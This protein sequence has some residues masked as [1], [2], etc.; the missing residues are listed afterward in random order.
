MTLSN[1]ALALIL[2]LAW[3][4]LL[5]G[6]IAALRSWLTLTGARAPNRFDPAG[7][8]VSAFA[9]RLCRAHANCYET[10]PLFGGLLLLALVLGR[11]DATDATALWALGARLGQSLVHLS[12]TSA[13]AVVV[14]FGFFAAQL[15]LFG[16]WIVRLLGI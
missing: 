1:T 14:R 9:G 10:F 12:S 4:L 3:T 2:Y 11:P 16:Y 13:T 15:G 8:D 5:I 6:G 7:S